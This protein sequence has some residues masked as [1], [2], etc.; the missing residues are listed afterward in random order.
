MKEVAKKYIKDNIMAHVPADIDVWA[1][2]NPQWKRMTGFRNIRPNEVF[3]KVTEMISKVKLPTDNN[4]PSTSNTPDT[5]TPDTN[6]PASSKP[7]T[8]KS[9]F[10][11]L[12]DDSQKDTQSR[13]KS[14][15]ELE[16]RRYIEFP[17]STDTDFNVLD[18]WN[19]HKS[20]FPRLFK[21][22]CDLATIS[23]TSASIERLFSHSGNTLTPKRNRLDPHVLEEIVFLNKN[24]QF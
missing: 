4:V 12:I 9:V 8:N 19:M 6:S 1:F 23:A 18:W 7:K 2:F 10:A 11:N 15:A 24:K 14:E 5:N 13:S 21:I 20:L 22:F 3:A 17:V 16:M